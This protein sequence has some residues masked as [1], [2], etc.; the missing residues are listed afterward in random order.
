[1]GTTCDVLIVTALGDELVPL[2][3][4]FGA[5]PIGPS[6][7]DGVFRYYE[8]SISLGAPG[9][10]RVILGSARA[11]GGDSMSAFL[12]RAFTRWSPSH[13]I[14]TGVAATD[15]STGVRLGQVMIAKTIVDVT[16]IKIRPNLSRSTVRRHA[17]DCDQ[18][19]LHPLECFAEEQEANPPRLGLI[20][21][22]SNL[23]KAAGARD[24][25]VGPVAA[26]FDEPPIGIEMEGAALVKAVAT[27]PRTKRPAFVM[28]KAAVDFGNFHK[29]DSQRQSAKTAVANFIYAFLCAG[30]LP[31]HSTVST[32]FQPLRRAPSPPLLGRARDLALLEAALRPDSTYAVVT[33]EGLGGIG[34]TALADC[35][36]D[37]LLGSRFEKLARF[38][39]PTDSLNLGEPVPL[40][41]FL[42]AVST[43]LGFDEVTS[44]STKELAARLLTRLR[45]ESVLIIIDNVERE[46]SLNEIAP[47]LREL[48]ATDP[49][50]IV[51]TSRVQPSDLLPNSKCISLH[52]L[53]PDDARKMLR[54]SAENSGATLSSDEIVDSAIAIIGGNPQAI[55][56][57]AG[58]FASY[59]AEVV[60]R[61]IRRGS[62]GGAIIYR[63]V[64][65][66]AWLTLGPAAR[67]L[68]VAMRHAPD[69]GVAWERLQAIAGVEAEEAEVGLGQLV[70]HNLL[71]QRMSGLMPLYV[72]HQLT[73]TFVESVVADW[74]EDSI[75][76]STVEA[77]RRNIEHTDTMLRRM[78]LA[79]DQGP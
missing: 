20:L 27:E 60:L 74:D 77:R 69:D 25:L 33:V 73:R 71:T 13:V 45:K 15:P 40:D 37:E 48:R 3:K 7:E 14:L 1:M 4:Q 11:K 21:S 2:R 30:W 42:T 44:A 66:S 5:K 78:G 22:Q 68:L 38:T 12:A 55:R 26:F 39:V 23:I 65:L 24:W 8:A 31:P 6:A 67:A 43:Q 17:Q 49:S 58:L 72:A 61:V 63:H 50:R 10:L 29:R 16:E 9:S 70:R 46:S 76:S 59:P 36:A 53:S 19:L 34:K 64:Y 32:S 56:I 62:G 57:V 51:L 54:T 75:E 28:I 47:W 79:D 35:A 41:Q 52:E 18:D